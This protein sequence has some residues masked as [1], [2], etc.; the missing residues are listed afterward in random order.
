MRYIGIDPGL[1]GAVA[2]I[3]ENGAI[4][5]FD[6]PTLTVKSGKKL[7]RQM[8]GAQIVD[9]LMREIGI[10]RSTTVLEKVSAMPGQGVS[11]TFNF[12]MGYGMWQGILVALRQPYTLVHPATWKKRLMADMGKEKEASIVRAKQLYPFIASQLS[13]KMDHGRADALL[14]AHYACLYLSG[15]PENQVV[16]PVEEFAL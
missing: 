2:I 3:E 4:R 13:R 5:L 9:L 12:G 8:D 11:S 14:L 16:E 6:T 7:H 1:T 10:G 15:A